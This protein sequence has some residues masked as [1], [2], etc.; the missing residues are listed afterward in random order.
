M[1]LAI[2]EAYFVDQCR[3]E[4]MSVANGHAV[5]IPLLGA[6][7][8]GATIG[9]S[10][11]RRRY[12]LRIVDV[13]VAPEHL[14]LLVEMLVDA[15]VKSTLN[16]GID[17][18]RLIVVFHPAQVWRGKELENL[19]G[20]GI[21]T[22][23]GKLIVGKSFSDIAIG[24][25]HDSTYGVH[26]PGGHGAGGG[27][28]E[29]LSIGE[30]PPQRVCASKVAG[31]VQKIREVGEAAACLRCGRHPYSTLQHPRVDSRAFVVCE[32]EGPVLEDSPA[33]N[34]PELV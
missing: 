11:K 14:V 27:R 15:H 34:G 22:P 10:F 33:G 31:C 6:I 1:F 8:V 29:N 18:G 21:Q 2:A 23:G 12:L 28:I 32:P 19:D 20:V 7:A 3:R 24:R 26:L 25:G 16:G 4:D 30:R 13:A 5:Y 9:D 17:R